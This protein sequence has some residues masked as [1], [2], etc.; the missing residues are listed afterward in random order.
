M[1]VVND[2][3]IEPGRARGTCLLSP[4][5]GIACLHTKQPRDSTV[6]PSRNRRGDRSNSRGLV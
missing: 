2:R 3:K 6:H 4:M 1:V 5:L